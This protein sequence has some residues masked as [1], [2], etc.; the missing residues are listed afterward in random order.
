MISEFVAADRGIPE[1]VPTRQIPFTSITGLYWQF[2]AACDSWKIEKPPSYELF[3]QWW[4]NKWSKVLK[5]RPVSSHAQ[6]TTCFD[7]EQLIYNKHT[8]HTQK[9]ELARRWRQHLRD[10]FLDRSI[11]WALRQASRDFDATLIVIIIDSVDKTKCAWPRYMFDRRPKDLDSKLGHRPRSVLTAALVH[12][13]F[14]YL[15]VAHDCLSHGED[16][17]CEVLVRT[18]DLVRN[19][20]RVQGR[21]FPVHLVI[22]SDNTTAQAKNSLVGCFLAHLVG[23]NKFAT[24]VLNFLIVGHTHE[25][26]DQ[27]FAAIVALVLK[28]FRW[29]TPQDLIRLLQEHLPQTVPDESTLYVEEVQAVRRFGKWLDPQCVTLHHAFATRDGIEAPH[30]FTYKR[31]SDL[32]FEERRLFEGHVQG[33]ARAAGY[34]RANGNSDDVFCLV[35][36]YMRDKR[37][38]QPPVLVLPVDRR[39]RATTRQ[40]DSAVGPSVSAERSNELKQM[41]SLLEK[42]RFGYLRAAAAMLK[43]ASCTAGAADA[44]PDPPRSAWMCDPPIRQEPVFDTQ[45]EYFGHLPETS[46]HLLVTFHKLS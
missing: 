27:W 45:N 13:W 42:P 34:T 11:Y 41:A 40:P 9:M 44:N 21:R 17:F 7:M 46:W 29:E 1:G 38:Q 2:L 16:A 23:A 18:L 19:Q 20:C 32:T 39:D 26:P 37:L 25:D 5:F 15:G 35:K 30:S 31:R 4:H 43:L 3:R 10:Q 36:T 28:K 6:C 14:H 24:A 8:A 12:G 22:Q 33:S